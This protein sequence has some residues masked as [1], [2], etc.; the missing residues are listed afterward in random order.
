MREAVAGIA[1]EGALV[2]DFYDRSRI[3][4]W[5]RSHPPLIAWTREKA[6]RPITGWQSYG[7]W[8]NPAELPGAVFESDGATR[9]RSGRR[10]ED[11]RLAVADGINHLRVTELGIALRSEA[12]EDAV[13]LMGGH[14]DAKGPD[15]YNL[16]LSDRR[17]AA[18]KAFLVE[19][20]AIRPER[21]IAVGYGEE[22]LKN[23]LDPEAAENR[24][25]TIVSL[26]N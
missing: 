21:L 5:L 24:R 10:G 7:A 12:L 16:A 4:T 17:A 15:N 8:A 25:V 9:L 18:V 20:F 14:T 22:R 13:F 3:A 11:D 19:T 26:A 2:L 1:N 23:S 6:G